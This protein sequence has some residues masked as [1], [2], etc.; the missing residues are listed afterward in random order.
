MKINEL[1]PEKRVLITAHDAFNYFGR[2]YDF[3]VLGLQGISTAAEAGVQDVQRL[4]DLIVERK[5]RA[6]FVESSVPL[7][8]IQALQQAV[9]SRGYNVRIGGSLF[10][11]A[12]GNPGTPEGTYHGMFLQNV[13]TIVNALKE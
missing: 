3:E 7:R 10:S 1:R 4:A 12:L 2:A 5:I 9:N 13:N 6:V 8:N 11:D